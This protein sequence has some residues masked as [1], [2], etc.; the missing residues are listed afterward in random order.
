V[1]RT[2]AEALRLYRLLFQRSVTAAAIV[3][4][5]DALLRLAGEATGGELAALLG[6]LAFVYSLAAPSLVQGAL[7]EIVRNVHEGRPPERVLPL[8]ELGRSRL[9]ALVRGSFLYALGIFG[10]LLLLVIPGFV[11][12]ARWSLIPPLVVIEQMGVL[13]ARRR[14]SELVRGQGVAVFWCL[15]FTLAI[16]SAVPLAVGLGRVSFGSS[17]FISFVWSSLTAPLAAHVLSVVYYRL[18]DPSR[19]VIDP[20]VLGWQSVWEGE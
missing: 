3:F 15:M 4:A 10:G 14:S 8:L 12:L 18:A 5:I 13:D 19:P 1:R 7:I 6:V 11:V 9:W 17:I 16:A 2:I 20:D